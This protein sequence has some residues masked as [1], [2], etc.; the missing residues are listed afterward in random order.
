[1]TANS[2]IFQGGN[3]ITLS[4]SNKTIVFSAAN[5]TVDTNK[6]G[7][8]YTSTTQGGSTVGITHNTAGLSMAWPPFIT[9]AAGGGGFQAGV[10]TDAAGTTGLVASQIVFFEGNTNITLSQSVNGNSASLSIFAP[11]GGGGGGAGYT[12]LTYQNRQLGA[13]TQSSAGIN[14]VWL[15]PMRVAAPVSASTL[16]VMQSIT[17]TL[18]SAVAATAAYTNDFIIYKQNST[19]A[20][21]FESV[22]STQN[23]MQFW[24]S[25]TSSASYGINGVTSSSAGT[26]LIAN[27]VY[28]LRLSTV[29]IGSI[30]DTGL[31]VY[32]H[33]QSSSTAGYASFVRTGG[34]IYDNPLPA[35]K[36]YFGA[37]TATSV[38]YN[39]GGIYSVTSASPPA[40]LA[41]SQI[42]QMSDVM[43]YV[44]IGA[45]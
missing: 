35:A 8:G 27:S 3:N 18:T 28:G 25:G 45:L 10:S 11:A 36:G 16:L 22:W 21:L 1:L 34:M 38:G 15:C 12:A 29:A 26:A 4:G 13:S 44:K 40:T 23:T 9:N 24:N 33:R 37:A 31:Y 17:G 20:T 5:Q 14:S 2:F 42:W 32:G 7:I 19:N 43:P 6:A 41:L 39:D 30:M